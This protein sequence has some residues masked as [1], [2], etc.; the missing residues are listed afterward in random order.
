MDSTM[1]RQIGVIELAGADVFGGDGIPLAGLG[2]LGWL[3]VGA[4]VVAVVA[5]W[6]DFKDG[7]FEG[8][9]EATH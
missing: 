4:L 2:K 6:E 1:L 7:C 5:N 3:A 9:N 8:Y